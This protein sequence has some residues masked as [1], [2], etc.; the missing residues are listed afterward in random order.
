M[1]YSVSWNSKYFVTQYLQTALAVWL[2][3]SKLG[4]K[5]VFNEKENPSK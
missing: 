5:P 4:N 3:H 2:Y 1:W